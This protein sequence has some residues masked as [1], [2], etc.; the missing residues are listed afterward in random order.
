MD[1]RRWAGVPFY[2]RTGKRLPQRMTEIALLFQ[3]APH[4]P[5]SATDT[6]ELGQNALVIRVQPARPEEATSGT[7][8]GTPTQQ[9]EFTGR[10]GVV[11]AFSFDGLMKLARE[12]D[13][14]V[15]QAAQS[16]CGSKTK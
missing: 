14:I 1:T 5:F 4:L 6:T 13:A 16:D 8:P 15:A 10:S 9:V 2:L 11:M 7:L 12:A 3:R